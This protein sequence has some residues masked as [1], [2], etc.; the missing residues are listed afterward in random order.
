MATKT[1]TQFELIE[2]EDVRELTARLNRVG[3][4]ITERG[5]T[6]VSP[7]LLDVPEH[8]S[9]Q[10]R[11]RFSA[12]VEFEVPASAVA[13]DEAP[14]VS[15]SLTGEFGVNRL[16]LRPD[17][18]ASVLGVSRA[19]IYRWL[20]DGEL[21]ATRRGRVCLVRMDDLRRWLNED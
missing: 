17:E 19:T 10:S 1:A 9:Q 7:H 15:G 18:V 11:T 4:A 12:L 21:P 16:A 13:H 14:I 6:F 8:Q 3:R 2:A 20:D 5:G